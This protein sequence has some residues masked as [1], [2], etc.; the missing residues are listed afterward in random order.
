MTPRP[1]AA[2]ALAAVLL[3]PAAGRANFGLFRRPLTTTTTYYYPAPVV[4]PAYPAYYYPAYTAP[5]VPVCPP[6]TPPVAAAPSRLYATPAPAPPSGTAEP[7]LAPG[8]SSAEPPRPG[9]NVQSE[10][11]KVSA[12]LYDTY[13][14]GSPG[15]RAAGDR[16]AVMFWNLSGRDMTLTV[17]GRTVSLPARQ[18]L[19]LDLRRDFTWGVLGREPQRQQV[20]ETEGGLEVVI[21]G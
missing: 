2:V 11:R 3:L 21:R 1:L 20:P 5:A 13:F 10:S 18:S 8:R 12:G 7:P 19:R 4:V 16:C 9:V 14:V 6:P 15:G 17:D